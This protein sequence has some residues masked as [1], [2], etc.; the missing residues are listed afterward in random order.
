MLVAKCNGKS[1]SRVLLV[2]I[3]ENNV[4]VFRQHGCFGD[5]ECLVYVPIDPFIGCQV[6]F[7]MLFYWHPC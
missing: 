7:T 3:D 6:Y 2:A 4:E 1:V 5:I